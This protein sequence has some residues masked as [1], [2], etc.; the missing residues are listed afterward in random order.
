MAEPKRTTGAPRTE[1]KKKKKPGAT[2]MNEA[3]PKDAR[4]AVEGQRVNAFLG[5]QNTRARGG[6]TSEGK[7]RWFSWHRI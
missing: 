1:L 2:H 7:G 6:H 3:K 5:V 4:G